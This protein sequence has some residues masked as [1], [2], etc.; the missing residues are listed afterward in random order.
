MT[1]LYEILLD[2][3]SGFSA[4]NKVLLLVNVVLLLFSRQIVQRIASGDRKS[5]KQVRLLHIFRAANLLVLLFILL[6][7][8]SCRWRRTPG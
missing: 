5:E 3:L 8:F 1:G 6:Y 2:T 7:K 4:T